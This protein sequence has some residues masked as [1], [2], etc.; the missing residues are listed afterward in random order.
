M[1][2]AHCKYKLKIPLTSLCGYFLWFRWLGLYSHV[3]LN[4][5]CNIIC[6]KSIYI[7]INTGTSDGQA[8]KVYKAVGCWGGWAFWIKLE[9]GFTFLSLPSCIDCFFKRNAA[10]NVRYLCI[11]NRFTLPA[12]FKQ[13]YLKTF[14]LHNCSACLFLREYYLMV[15]NSAVGNLISRLWHH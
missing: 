8:T 3:C 10:V 9:L 14:Y 4:L 12:N 6:L 15:V 11:N 5:Y 7:G 13:F 1:E 2:I